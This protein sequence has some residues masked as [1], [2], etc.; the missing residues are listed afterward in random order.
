MSGSATPVLAGSDISRLADHLFRHEAGKLVSIL[1]GIFGISRLQLA[2]DV[3]QEALVRALKTWPFYGVPDNPA[4]WL[5][6]TA[7]NL[8]LDVV[9][10]ERL[11][12]EKEP[13]I[14]AYMEQWSGDSESPDSAKFDSEIKDHRLRLMFACCHPLIP[15]E[16]QTALALKTL[17]GFSPA[18]IASAF[19]SSEAAIAKRLT[20]ARQKIHELHI[21]FEI[22]AGEEIPMRLESVLQTLYLLF[23]EGYKA[24][25]GE[26]LVREELCHEAIR[27]A[28]LLSAHPTIEQPRTHALLALMFLNAARLAARTDADGNIVRLEEQDRS[29]WD[30]MMIARGVFHLGKSAAGEE[31]SEYHLQ[32]AI[33]A[34]H[35]TAPDYESTDWPRILSLYD[36]LVEIDDSPVVALNRAVAVANVHG[37]QAGIEAVEAIQNLQPLDSYYLLYAVLGD[38]EEQLNRFDA[39]A[40]HFRKALQFTE[41]RSEQLFLSKRVRDCEERTLRKAAAS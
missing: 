6:Q 10:R 36:H 40:A 26:T 17:C 16:A 20:R 25:S 14:V 39:A 37:P 2:E 5:T 24:S 31:V 35:C 30:Q 13:E 21:P 28:T 7:K 12:H 38:F 18:E 9:R 27:L 34:A 32:A 33:A 11:F 1:T 3:V 15:R 19:L 4:A 29:G 23:N 41:L 22:P 8:A